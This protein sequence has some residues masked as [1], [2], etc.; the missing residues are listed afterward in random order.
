MA[1][2]LSQRLEHQEHALAVRLEAVKSLRAALQR[3]YGV[4]GDEQKKTAEELLPMHG[5]MMRLG[6]I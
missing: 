1:P 4:L 6:V 2:T 3:L 5:G